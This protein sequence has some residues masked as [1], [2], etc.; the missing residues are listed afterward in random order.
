MSLVELF[1][2]K[3]LSKNGEVNTADIKATNVLV[4]F[5]A[6]WCP[7]CRGFTPVLADA[8]KQSPKAGTDTIVIFVSSD[9]DQGGFD[10]Y[11]GEMPWHALPFDNR[12]KKGTLAQKF[13]VSGIPK[14]VVLGGD[15][16]LVSENG[17]AEYSSYL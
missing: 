4:Y 15:G 11:Y 6:H 9:R 7:P 8:Y 13:N 14:L 12:E 10:E 1:G 17:R 5:S 2:D 3:L 16:S